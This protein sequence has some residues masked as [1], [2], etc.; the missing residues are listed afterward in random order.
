MPDY[1]D[2]HLSTVRLELRPLRIEDQQALFAIYSD[3]DFMRYWSSQPWTN[4]EQ[5]VQLIASDLRDLAEGRHIRLAI[6]TRADDRL[7]GT[8]S[9]FNINTQCRRAEIGYGIARGC[10]RK[11]F[12][13]EAV[14]ALIDHAFQAMSLHR[15]EADIDPLNKASAASLERLGFVREGLLRERWIVDGKVSDSALYGLLEND[16]RRNNASVM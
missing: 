11:G 6:V 13:K 10:W 2:L 1:S 4:L 9:L 5:A 14:T 7:I 12:M 16:W 15:I 8:C 3:P